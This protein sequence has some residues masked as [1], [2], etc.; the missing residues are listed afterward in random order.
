MT[1]AA[2]TIRKKARPAARL[3]L[4]SL[5]TAGALVAPAAAPS[6][7]DSQADILPQAELEL[8]VTR[9]ADGATDTVELICQLSTPDDGT[10]PNPAAACD[11]LRAVGGDFEQL[12]DAGAPCTR[13]Y[14]PHTV[15]ATGRWDGSIVDYEET[16]ANRCLAGV[17]TD[18]VFDF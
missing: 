7:A 13:E 2:P 4:A 3:A 1:K 9:D 15:T 6:A 5:L 12:P 17:G 16:F 14:D 10:H 18:Y 8:S 11:S